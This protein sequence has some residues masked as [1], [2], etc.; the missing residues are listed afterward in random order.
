MLTLALE[1]L[2]AVG[3]QL[4]L[5]IDEAVEGLARD[6]QL[7]AQVADLSPTSRIGA[8]SKT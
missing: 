3:T 7:L 4:P 2:R 1:Q 5:G 6:A 8:V